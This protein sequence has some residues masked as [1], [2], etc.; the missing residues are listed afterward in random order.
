MNQV[1]QN[2]PVSPGLS[3]V[4]SYAEFISNKINSVVF[5]VKTPKIL[6]TSILIQKIM[7][8]IVEC[9]NLLLGWGT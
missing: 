9:F 1:W 3:S 2:S 5:L 8:I 4:P 6:S 7:E